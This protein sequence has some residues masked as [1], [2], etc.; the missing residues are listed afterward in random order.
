MPPGAG[1]KRLIPFS[2]ATGRSKMTTEEDEISI[3]IESLTGTIYE[4]TISVFETI[5]AIKARI[6]RLEGRRLKVIT[7]THSKTIGLGVLAVMFST[8]A[9]RCINNHE[10]TLFRNPSVSTAVSI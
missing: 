6:Q 3:T 10:F 2:K 1:P 8:D 9:H 7:F 4:L 5:L